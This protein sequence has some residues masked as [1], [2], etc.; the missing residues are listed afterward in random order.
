MTD[1]VSTAVVQD[2]RKR[3]KRVLGLHDRSSKTVGCPRL[4]KELWS[5][6]K[7]PSRANDLPR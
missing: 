2:T 3:L 5:Q 4:E 7:P 1:I 6:C